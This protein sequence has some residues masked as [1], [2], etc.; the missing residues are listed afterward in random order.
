M[1]TDRYTSAECTGAG[2][3]AAGLRDQ[4]NATC[5][6]CL[7]LTPLSQ[8]RRGEQ[9]LGS[10]EPDNPT[11]FCKVGLQAAAWLVRALGLLQSEL[12]LGQAVRNG[13]LLRWLH[14]HAAA[15]AC[16][17]CPNSKQEPIWWNLHICL[18][19]LGMPS[20]QRRLGARAL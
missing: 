5:M 12:Q 1:N 17:C 16:S 13:P 4:V 20:G 15:V 10:A 14:L 2:D 6:R 18:S 11:L 8:A 3:A 19:S 7:A 9:R